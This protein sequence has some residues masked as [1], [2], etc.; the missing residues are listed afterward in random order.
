MLDHLLGAEF[1]APIPHHDTT[2]FGDPTATERVIFL[3]GGK[4]M[5][6][7]WNMEAFVKGVVSFTIAGAVLVGAG[8]Y[9]LMWADQRLKN[10]Q[11]PGVAP[12]RPVAK[13]DSEEDSDPGSDAH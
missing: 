13:D 11:K 10:K 6:V 3:P 5:I 8:A 9:G 2:S 1:H 12:R 4:A 7:D